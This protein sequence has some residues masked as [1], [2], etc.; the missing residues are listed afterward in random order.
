M[1][2]RRFAP[3]LFALVL[4]L[5][6]LS[7]LTATFAE[8][9]ATTIET[10]ILP[11]S[12]SGEGQRGEVRG[13]IAPAGGPLPLPVL[14]TFPNTWHIGTQG[15]AYVDS[16]DLL[17]YVHDQATVNPDTLWAIPSEPP[18]TPEGSYNLALLNPNWRIELNNRNGVAYD[19]NSG[20]FFLPDSDGDQTLRDDNIIEMDIEGTIVNAWETDGVSND[21]SDGSEIDKILDIAIVFDFDNRYFVTNGTNTLYEIAL[22][23]DGLWIDDSWSTVA[24]CVLP[25]TIQAS[26]IEYDIYSGQLLVA[27]KD[28]EVITAINKDC[29][30]TQQFLCDGPGT[31]HTGL[32][33]RISEANTQR[34]IW[35]TDPMSNQ[36]T[37]CAYGLK[38]NVTVGTDEGVCATTDTINVQAGTDVT[39]CYD[40]TNLSP[41]AYTQHDLKDSELGNLLID[42]PYT[43][44]PGASAFITATTPITA[45]TVSTGTWVSQ[46]TNEYNVIYIAG[47]CFEPDLGTLTPLNLT[48]DAEANL[49]L[50]F[51][52]TLYD[53]TSNQIRVG[54]NGGILVGATTGDIPDVNSSLPTGTVPNAIL[55]YWDDIDEEQGNVYHG[56][57]AN[58]LAL[59]NTPLQGGGDT[60]LY[61]ILWHQR[62]LFPGAAN[63]DTGTFLVGLAESDTDADNG[64]V[65]CYRDT[66]FEGTVGDGG[67]AAT[68]GLNKDGTL[69]SLVS[70]N[71]QHPELLS[72][73]AIQYLPATGRDDDS[74]T[75]NVVQTVPT[76]TPTRTATSAPGTATP[77]RTPTR[78]P[79]ATNSRTYCQLNDLP[80]PDAN[81]SG[82]SNSITIADAFLI[83]DLNVVLSGT[84][85]YVGDLAFRL[86]NGTTQNTFFDRPGVPA[87]T[88][89]CS[90]DHLPTV[91]ADDE[92]AQG[93]LENSCQPNL[94]AY[95]PNGSYTP[96]SPLS[97]YEGGT[98]AGTWTLNASDAAGGDTGVLQQWCLEFRIGGAAPTATPTRTPTATITPGG[99]TLT[100]TG[101][102][103]R[104]AT[105]T[106]TQTPA[107][108]RTP[109]AT[110]TPGGA[111]VT[112]T[113]TSSSGEKL[114]LPVIRRG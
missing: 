74:A 35:V 55:P 44:P 46:T 72:D 4:P 5:F 29:M 28:S 8:R 112:P 12:T 73:F 62:P 85:T 67:G 96:N 10:S 103:T 69:A 91:F 58:P 37:R 90:G 106:R 43:L 25:A 3:L 33:I 57:L 41:V 56:L 50:P 54:N 89:G 1:P 77:T 114:Y 42:F 61:V 16:S 68:L 32:A 2:I 14:E 98:T 110:I 30:Q 63:H 11:L 49:A 52:L 95:T 94:P 108:T 64:I 24:T 80:I 21:S 92:G 19:L 113:P 47:S 87:S 99:P 7:T 66:D 70:F 31:F 102:P 40:V 39:Y 81:P 101:T 20:T 83:Q 65:V 17:L 27:D 88:F 38:V 22:N 6:L 75:V 109:T 100:P 51:N 45:T 15:L 71:T 97:V 18:Y 79:T 105:P 34:E 86:S 9:E 104:T 60:Q 23:R 107:P 59:T 93:S 111:T 13:E 78:T 53:T 26:G 82:V 48:D 84:H 76:N 36:T